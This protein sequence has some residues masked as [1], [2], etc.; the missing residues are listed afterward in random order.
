MIMRIL[1]IEWKMHQNLRTSITKKKQKKLIPLQ[2]KNLKKKK[3]VPD[4][5]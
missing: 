3:K 2:R 5:N 1:S 4:S